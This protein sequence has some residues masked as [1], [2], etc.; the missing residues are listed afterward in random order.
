[1]IRKNTTSFIILFLF[2]ISTGFSQTVTDSAII[3]LSEEV[4]KFSLN[5]ALKN[6][7]WG[8]CVIT[9]DS[10]KTVFAKNDSL[11]L[12]PASTMKA[13]STA[14]GLSM[15]GSKY[16]FKTQLLYDGTIDKDSTLHGNLYIK[17]GGDP[18]LGS[19]RIDTMNNIKYMIPEWVNIIQS[20]GIKKIEGAIVGD[21]S[22]LDD[23]IVPPSWVDGDIGFYYGAG[24]S[25][26]SFHENN[27]L[28]SIT[29]GKKYR[30]S[31]R[32]TEMNPPLPYIK[33]EN[34]AWTGSTHYKG[35]LWAYGKPY[36]NKRTIT[37]IVPRNYKDFKMR[38]SLPDPAAFCAYSLYKALTDTGI[39]VTDSATTYK[40][41]VSAKKNT[42]KERT[43]IYTHTSPTLD[44]L[45]YYTN[46]KSINSYAENILKVL[47]YEKTGKGSTIIGTQLVKAYWKMKGV[48]LNG[49]VMKDGSGLSTENKV[50]P[51]QLAEMMRANISDS[52]FAVYYHSLPSAGISGTIK[53][54]LKGTIAENNLRAKSGYMKKIRSYTGYVYNKQNK[55]LTFGIIVNNHTASA[56]GMRT[57]LE[58]IMVMIAETE[59]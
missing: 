43:L 58:K 56:I 54:M 23:T 19:P 16:T 59:W 25:G 46:H 47:A 4:Q 5:H 37:G 6:A 14:A 45:V 53:T 40:E 15:L 31:A 17:G 38:L 41:L 7:K 24:A 13:I 12:I 32:I 35:N 52:T 8:I 9:A 55:L 22:I 44:T 11:L 36:E 1:M 30:D 50:S 49:F 29:C 3:K 48:N 2:F 28:I 33:L 39:T 26:L 21:A 10:G 34:K 20:K 51:R 27:F 57:M 18:S 42:Y